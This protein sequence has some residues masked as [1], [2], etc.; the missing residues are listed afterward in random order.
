MKIQ[1][2]KHVLVFGM[3]LMFFGAKIQNQLKLKTVICSISEQFWLNCIS[4]HY[5]RHVRNHCRML[6][7]K[8]HRREKW[9][10]STRGWFI[11]GCFSKV[12]ETFWP[13]SRC[14][15]STLTTA[16]LILNRGFW[17][18][19]TCKQTNY[20]LFNAHPVYLEN[21][22]IPCKTSKWDF[23]EYLQFLRFHNVRN[24]DISDILNLIKSS[25]FNIRSLVLVMHKL[26]E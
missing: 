17:M 7:T 12:L 15:N 25:S 1:I 4:V 23:L 13:Q 5:G 11:M 20:M 24:M 3:E 21:S 18:C 26:I 16:K 8:S 9:K 2:F 14:I 19:R 6:K 22:S 10:I